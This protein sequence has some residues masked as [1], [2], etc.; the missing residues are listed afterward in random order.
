MKICTSFFVPFWSVWP[1]VCFSYSGCK[2]NREEKY[3]YFFI[4]EVKICI[5]TPFFVPFWSVWPYVGHFYSGGSNRKIYTP[6]LGTLT[7]TCVVDMHYRERKHWDNDKCIAPITEE[8]IKFKRY[9][10][11]QES[12]NQ[13]I[14]TQTVKLHHHNSLVTTQFLWI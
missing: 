11:F 6:P 10:S 3:A 2:L 4:N 12:I 7:P 13:S 14:W 1:Y 5:I 9:E 8:E